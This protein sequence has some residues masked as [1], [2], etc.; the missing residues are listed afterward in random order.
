[1]S[2]KF[3]GSYYFTTYSRY[4]LSIDEGEW[5]IQFER[6]TDAALIEKK[7]K[8]ALRNVRDLYMDSYVDTKLEMQHEH[9]K[10]TNQIIK[11]INGKVEDYYDNNII[12]DNVRIWVR[13]DIM[14]NQFDS[15]ERLIPAF[16][17]LLERSQVNG[18]ETNPFQLFLRLMG[19]AKTER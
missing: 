1:M 2:G 3:T 18:G 19:L 13:N 8:L 15:F 7:I 11:A 4:I 17:D 5:T 12:V 10:C 6:S 14:V 16:N 9:D